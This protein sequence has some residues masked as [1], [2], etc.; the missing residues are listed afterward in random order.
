MDLKFKGININSYLAGATVPHWL[1][2]IVDIPQSIIQ[3]KAI[4]NLSSGSSIKNIQ[5]FLFRTP[6]W[7][8]NGVYFDGI[9]K[10]E[11]KSTIKL[12]QYP[13]Q[14]GCTGT[15]HAVVE[16]AVLTIDVMMSDANNIKSFNKADILDSVF[17][18]LKGLI[19]NSNYVEMQRDLT[20][21]GRSINA[22]T[23]LRGMQL[24]RTPITV[25]TRLHTYKNMVI[26]ELTAPDD[27]K[28][29][30]ALKCTVRLRE[31]ITVGV[32]TYESSKRPMETETPTN[33]GEAQGDFLGS[34]FLNDNTKT[35]TKQLAE[36]F[37]GSV[38]E[39]FK[40]LIELFNKGGK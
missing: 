30:T 32:S 35:K 16:P 12:T 1:V 37:H 22:W 25:E 20:G 3:Q 40:E 36:L 8:I 24:S 11:H 2:D 29:Y 14:S 38:K 17:Q 39:G 5:G 10:T 26:E 18:L 4:L 21:E 9:M 28:T 15:D 7:G 34:N 6:K 19:K 27:V 31:I 33:I 13:I 23:V